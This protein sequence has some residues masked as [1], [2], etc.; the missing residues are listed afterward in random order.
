MPRAER[1]GR[2]ASPEECAALTAAVHRLAGT[3]VGE[4]GTLFKVLA[5]TPAGALPPAPFAG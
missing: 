1:L 2:D 3:G 4:M 5:V